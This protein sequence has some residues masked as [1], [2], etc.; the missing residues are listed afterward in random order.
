MISLEQWRSAIGVFSCTHPPLIRMNW[1]TVQQEEQ[2]STTRWYAIATVGL[3]LF[4][5]SLIFITAMLLMCSG[6]VE[7]NPGPVNC[8]KCPSCQL[9]TVPVKCRVCPCGHI[10]QKK[11]Y[12]QSPKCLFPVTTS[13]PVT[14]QKEVVTTREGTT[15]TS[16]PFVVQ[17]QSHPVVGKPTTTKGTVNVTSA[18]GN[19]NDTVTPAEGY[20]TVT[21]AESNDTVTPS[22]GDDTVINAVMDGVRDNTATT[23]ISPAQLQSQPVRIS[24]PEGNNVVPAEFVIN[25]PSNSNHEPVILP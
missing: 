9:T 24:A 1:N 19:D 25:L 21:P 16:S 17:T 12:R 7:L 10:F 15:I 22:E 23:T 8:K 3:L 2:V 18:K 13:Q 6:D 20:N 5:N 14:S 4:S 11:S